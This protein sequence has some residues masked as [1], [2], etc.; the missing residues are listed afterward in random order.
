LPQAHRRSR[1]LRT[2]PR[3]WGPFPASPARR[4]RCRRIGASSVTPPADA[5]C[6]SSS[7]LRR[8]HTTTSAAYAANP[9]PR[10]TRPVSG[11]IRLVPPLPR[12]FSQM[13]PRTRP[14]HPYLAGAPLLI[15]HR[16]GA[17]LAPENTVLAFRQAIDW[18]GADILEID[19]HPS[20]DG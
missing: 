9:G 1:R 13:P 19:V 10:L 16:G 11:G 3:P 8:P 4:S 6:P 2:R 5:C 18:W 14:G 15:A 12:R 7:I 17:A 20:A